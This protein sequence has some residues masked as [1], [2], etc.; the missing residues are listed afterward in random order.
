MEGIK[1]L[2]SRIRSQVDTRSVDV[3]QELG[4][5]DRTRTGII[6]PV[7]LHRWITS[8]GLNFDNQEIQ[9]IISAYQR[10]DGVD[11]RKL[12][13]DIHNSKSFIEEYSSRP[14][15]CVEDLQ[16][17][18]MYLN[19]TRQ[20]VRDALRPFDPNNKRRVTSDHFFRAF[21][22][23]QLTKTIV[24]HYA[25]TVTGMIDYFKLQNDIITAGSSST[26]PD[27]PVQNVPPSFD[28]L[29]RFIKTRHINLEAAFDNRYMDAESRYF[30]STQFNTGKVTQKKFEAFLSSLG[31]RI[32]LS[33]V[34][35]ISKCFYDKN[36]GL[37]NFSQFINTVE[38]YKL[39]PTETVL[40][41]TLRST[42]PLVIDTDALIIGISK[43]VQD[44]RIDIEYYF[45]PFNAENAD[46]PITPRRFAQILANIQ[47]SLD[48]DE[49]KALA[50]RYTVVHNGENFVDYKKFISDVL[51]RPEERRISSS[52][53]ID[54][55][56]KY[57]HQNVHQYF[58]SSAARYDREN[59]GSVTINQLASAL[60]FIGFE[61]TNAELFAIAEAYPGAKSG[62][63]SWR[64]IS[65]LVES[66]IKRPGQGIIEDFDR[67]QHEAFQVNSRSRP[68]D[69]ILGI[70]ANIAK[71]LVN[72]D[73]Y[74]AFRRY[75]RALQGHINQEH[76]TSVLFALPIHIGVNDVRALMTYYRISGT[77]DVNYTSFVHD[78]RFA[79]QNHDAL[80]RETKQE[81]KVSTP[82]LQNIPDLSPTVQNFLGRFKSF[83]EANRL[84]V[85]EMFKLYD[86]SNNGVIQVFK[87]PAVFGNV[88]FTA[89]RAELEELCNT[90]RDQRRPEFFDFFLFER[91]LNQ[92]DITDE[93][94]RLRL[95][96]SPISAEV[97]RE[98]V[99]TCSLIREKLLA[100]HRRIGIA[101]AGVNTDTITT[102]EFQRRL[103][104]LNIVIRAG[105]LTALLR[106][107]R[108]GLTN[109]VKWKDFVNDVENSKTI[110]DF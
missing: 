63:V 10:A 39:K 23:S 59:S 80:L 110:G 75:D 97:A 94:V 46:I 95:S 1:G 88:H 51:P 56:N 93:S 49:M 64:E 81:T 99:T 61:F 109:Q 103:S 107:Y 98:A 48:L 14:P 65:K 22:V 19:Q 67:Q 25:D 108:L 29:V 4:Y 27:G 77:P 72:Y 102:E 60:Q 68:K 26:D 8:L 57:L 2:I 20:T 50:Q 82:R 76:F 91:A 47:L 106:R 6:S 13:E 90:F 38:N 55:L 58:A 52:D 85:Q 66:D 45:A 83:A 16:Q 18:G 101:F 15:H 5:Y 104:D 74:S 70:L 105:Q 42:K 11:W 87:V 9:T 96:G 30:K 34:S 41:A 3:E 43:L 40:E 54:R 100:R 69:D 24:K 73:L 21:G 89:V 31:A 37:Y 78:L 36:T 79:P 35:E 62:Q 32:P 28:E 84:S 17:F 92:I 53:V 86:R 71:N 44:R 7:S 33:E 12:S